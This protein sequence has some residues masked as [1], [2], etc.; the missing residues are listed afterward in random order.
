MATKKGTFQDYQ[1]NELRPDLSAQELLD[2]I[3]TVD[4]TGSGL[5]ADLL[6]GKSA[7]KFA[8]LGE[9][10][11][12]PAD[13]LPSDVG[14]DTAGEILSKLRT[15]DGANSGLDADLLD[16]KHGYQYQGVLPDGTVLRS[17]YMLGAANEVKAN[18]SEFL[19]NYIVNVLGYNNW[20]AGYISR[21]LITG[22][23][24]TAIG[25]GT[26]GIAAGYY[27]AAS[28]N[29]NL[30][31][32]Q[33]I[34]ASSRDD[35]EIFDFATTYTNKTGEET[36]G[37]IDIF[38]TSKIYFKSL[39]YY[40][41]KN[42]MV[43]SLWGF[44]TREIPN[45]INR[46]SSS[47]IKSVGANYVEL[48]EE[49]TL[50]NENTSAGLKNKIKTSANNLNTNVMGQ[51]IDVPDWMEESAL[52]IGNY[53]DPSKIGSFIVANGVYNSGV[54][55]KSNSFRVDESGKGIFK[56]GVS[57][58]GADF[59]EY[60]EVNDI[61]LASKDI[62]GRFVTLDGDKIRIATNLDDFVLG[63]ISSDPAITGNSYDEEWIGK[64]D[65]DIFGAVIY[66][67]EQV[68]KVTNDGSVECIP[69]MMAQVSDEFDANQIYKG[70][71]ERTE[72]K[73][74]ALIGQVVIVDDGTC[75]V[76][77]YCF[78]N[79]NGIATA[80][81]DKRGYRVLK[82]KDETHVLVYV[83]GRIVL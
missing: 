49:I 80:T 2:K 65:R 5:D 23:C 3:K 36:S 55:T 17:G 37:N 72:W 40:H 14:K 79:S 39:S 68:P 8:Q 52:I 13:S 81:E 45:R 51:Y 32:G 4:G 46:L 12:L 28:I 73:P 58:S 48:W 22:D 71:S 66:R 24:I 62:R 27:N 78:P 33:Y 26:G 9:D 60:F 50:I 34:C 56:N 41:K 74:V 64:Y 6:G 53:N 82:R 47:I 42:N 67:E 44:E 29:Y 76:N 69:K 35:S 83:H 16:G 21:S 59:A 63:V 75:Q 25:N 10:G 20:P 77:G 38:Q 15:V 1:G 30:T 57:N 54:Y 18:P 31:V 61:S 7:D 43:S 19:E 70:R 11:K